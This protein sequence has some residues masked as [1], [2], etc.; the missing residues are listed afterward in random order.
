M[1]IYIWL[2]LLC[3]CY[4]RKIGRWLISSTISLWNIFTPLFSR[5]RFILPFFRRWRDRHQN[6]YRAIAV[7]TYVCARLGRVGIDFR[8]RIVQFTL[9]VQSPIC[10]YQTINM[11]DTCLF[12]GRITCV[13]VWKSQL[14]LFSNYRR[15]SALFS[16]RDI[17]RFHKWIGSLTFPIQFLVMIY[18]LSFIILLSIPSEC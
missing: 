8:E 9:G 7:G 12:I 16:Y 1:L 15:H 18:S 2:C 10:I 13:D 17:S 5:P 14:I 6:T 3:I 11:Q 4:S